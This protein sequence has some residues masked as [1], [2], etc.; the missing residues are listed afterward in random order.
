[1]KSSS[2]AYFIALD[3]VRALAAFMVYTWHFT[4]AANGYPVPFEYVP[5]LFPFSL[6]DEGHTGVALFITL[7]GYLFAKL[8]DGKTIDYKAFLWN[9][10][11]RL[12]PLLAVVILIIGVMKFVSG[13]SL[14]RY[15]YSIAKGALIPSL[16]NGGWS[17]TVEF[18]YYIILPLFLWMLRKSKLLPISIVIAAIALRMLIHHEMGEIQTLAYW[19]IF[20]R[21]DQFAL[22]MIIYQFRSYLAHRHVLAIA[23][24]VA[25]SM[26]YWY[27]DL[28]GGFYQNPSYPS[29]SPLWILF[30]TIEG[31]AYAVGIAWYESSFSPP[32]TG[33]S[34]FI[35]RIGE[36]SYSI[37][38]L[39]FFVVFH[40]AEFVNERIMDIS[41]FYLACIWSVIFFLLMMP[42]GYLSF[43]F[44]EA[45]F[46]KL[47]KRYYPL[48]HAVVRRYASGR[49]PR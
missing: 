21:I 32:T 47:R 11:L 40:A 1:M 28:Q 45:P 43:R 6:L 5:A 44:I 42:A 3:H 38:L 25:F 48:H 22:G 36:Y 19:T 24:I 9:R 26:F 14:Q 33:V 35:G 13:E 8:L 30:P 7:S 4:H 49:R 29:P 10:A 20:G 39:H 15:A 17:L 34:R 46:L 27:F 16:P 2:G 41:N 31:I 12:L 23:T 37:Y 18:H